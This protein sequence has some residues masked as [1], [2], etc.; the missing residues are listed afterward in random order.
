MSGGPPI[1]RADPQG[2]AQAVQVI[3]SD[4]IVAFPTET[5][6]GLGVDALS[7]AALQRL[8]AVKGRGPARPVP[9]LVANREML[10]RLVVPERIPPLALELMAA[11]WPG[12]LTL[13]L[14]ARPSVP[15]QLVN[16]RGGVGVR[17]SSDPVAAELVRRGGRPVTA[18]SANRTGQPPATS[19]QAA[20]LEGVQLVLDDGPRACPPTTVVEVL[21]GVPPV[22]VRQGTLKPAGI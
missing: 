20:L 11:H 2:I 9:V 13:V 15:R 22:V 17:I 19:A 14:A 1:V 18:T 6:Y 21:P 8:E 3:A 4:G 16:P 5:L 12:P 10:E 7:V